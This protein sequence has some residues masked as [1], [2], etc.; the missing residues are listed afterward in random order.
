M[1]LRMK[2]RYFCLIFILFNLL[3]QMTVFYLQG[4]ALV[5]EQSNAPVNVDWILNQN[6]TIDEL[7]ELIKHTQEDLKV[8]IDSLDRNDKQEI[9]KIIRAKEC[10][11]VKHIK[12]ID[13]MLAQKFRHK[14]TGSMA[15]RKIVLACKVIGIMILALCI[16]ISSYDMHRDGWSLPSLDQFI[17]NI[18]FVT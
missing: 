6:I 9:L 8:R 2:K 3:Q 1:F 16:L 18:R 15:H 14:K 5:S 4:D 12:D 10:A 7:K 17:D 11:I 13:V